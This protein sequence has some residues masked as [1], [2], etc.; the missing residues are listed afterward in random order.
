MY[1]GTKES[2]F[3]LLVSS[4]MEDSDREE[5]NK[6]RHGVSK[7]LLYVQMHYRNS[8]PFA[9]SLLVATE[10]W[11]FT[12][13]MFRIQWVIHKGV[14]DVLFGWCSGFSKNRSSF[15]WKSAPLCFMWTVWKERNN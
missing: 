13:A 10:L 3:L 9:T 6:K 7:L 14:I 12:F 8:G 1:L 4:M 11:S 5:S 2:C 15:V